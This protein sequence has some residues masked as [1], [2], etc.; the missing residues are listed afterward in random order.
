MKVKNKSLWKGILVLLIGFLIFTFTFKVIY[1]NLFYSD[2]S[3]PFI[4]IIGIILIICGL[5]LLIKEKVRI[6]NFLK[7]TKWKIIFSLIMFII[8]GKILLDIWSYL[9]QGTP[10]CLAIGC[11]PIFKASRMLARWSF[12]ILALSYLFSSI[13]MYLLKILKK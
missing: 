3:L 6:N 2:L 4:H 11:H 10:I 13:I 5:Y 1:S 7:P 9:P 8:V 12:L